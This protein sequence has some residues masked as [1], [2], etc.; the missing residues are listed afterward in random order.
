MNF[1]NNKRA[2][3]PLGGMPPAVV[4]WLREGK[5]QT[6]RKVQKTSLIYIRYCP[7]KGA[8]HCFYAAD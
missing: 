7:R 3:S 8:A 1:Y 5:T 6:D 4:Y 2:H